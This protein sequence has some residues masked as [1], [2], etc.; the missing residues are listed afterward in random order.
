MLIQVRIRLKFFTDTF[1][2][3]V[4]RELERCV[5]GILGNEYLQTPPST[6]P[7]TAFYHKS[8]KQRCRQPWQP[9]LWMQFEGGSPSLCDLEIEACGDV[10]KG[11][12]SIWTSTRTT[13][14]ACRVLCEA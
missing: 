8:H 5:N 2:F 12:T 3:Q 4:Q 14:G 11:D 6:F 9:Q 13:K 7:P 1:L 10:K